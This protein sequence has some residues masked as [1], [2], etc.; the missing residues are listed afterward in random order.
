M[1]VRDNGIPEE[2][3]RSGFFDPASVLN[4]FGLTQEVHDLVEI[5]PHPE[6]C[7]A[8]GREAGFRFN[9]HNR[10]N[11]PPYHYGLLFRKPGETARSRRYGVQATVTSSL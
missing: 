8:W 1:K 5:R 6:Q 10:Y 4:I 11:L 3:M 2:E 7:I 9:K